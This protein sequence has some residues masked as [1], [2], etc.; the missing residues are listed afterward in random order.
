MKLPRLSTPRRR[1]DVCHRIIN[2]N[3]RSHQ[4]KIRAFLSHRDGLRGS[5]CTHIMPLAQRTLLGYRHCRGAMSSL[6]SFS[7]IV[8]MLECLL[9]PPLVQRFFRWAC[10]RTASRTPQGLVGLCLSPKF[11]TLA[12]SHYTERQF[13]IDHPSPAVRSLL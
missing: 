6:L 9:L 11:L 7:R 10:V 12:F 13:E 8:L 4:R 5:Y 1:V 2:G 3:T